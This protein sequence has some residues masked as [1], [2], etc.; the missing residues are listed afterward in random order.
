MA[1]CTSCGATLDPGARACSRCGA[2]VA[3]VMAGQ[4]I[5]TSPQGTAAGSTAQTVPA[6]G[7][8]SALKIILIIVA[9][10]VGLFLLAGIAVSWG[11]WRV[12]HNTRIHSDKNGARVETPFG[13]VES[14]NDSAQA[15]RDLGVDPYPG[16]K[17]LPG[18]ASVNFGGMRTASAEFETS[19]SLDKVDAFYR[20]RYPNANVNVSDE[21]QHTILIGTPDKR[22]ITINIEPRGDVTHIQISNIRGGPKSPSAPEPR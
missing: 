16:A 11:V 22:M 17:V 2:T 3:G 9:V 10:L 1:F 5:S 19:D 6:A 12:A 18:G 7:S 20:Q 8:G 13:T 21:N 14:S 15:I 4:S